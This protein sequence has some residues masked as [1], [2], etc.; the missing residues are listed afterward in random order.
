MEL[1]L[2]DKLKVELPVE[3]ELSRWFAVW[4]APGFERA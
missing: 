1:K 3:P 2:R 4:D